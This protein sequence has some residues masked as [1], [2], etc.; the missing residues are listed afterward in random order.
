MERRKKY[1]AYG[2]NLNLGQMARRCPT[3][4]VIGKGEIKDHELLFRGGSL[5]AVATVEPKAGSNVPV[6]IWEIEPEDER[7]LDIY[8][9]YPRLYGKVDLEVQTEDGS[10]SIMAYTMNEGH[11]IGKPSMRYLETITTGY[12][13]AGFD[14]NRL[15]QSVS[16]CSEDKRGFYA[17]LL[18]AI[19]L[20]ILLYHEI[21]HIVNGHIDYIKDRE[22]ES[23]IINDLP[24]AFS[25]VGKK[26]RPFI[27]PEEWQAL[28]WNADDFSA[29]RIVEKYLSS[30]TIEKLRLQGPQQAVAIIVSSYTAL[31]TLME[32][33]VRCENAEEY[34]SFEHLPKRIRLEKSLA[35][36]YDYFNSFKSYRIGKESKEYLEYYK[37]IF[38]RWTGLFLKN[39][40]LDYDFI[41]IDENN[42]LEE[43]DDE[44]REYYKRVENYYLMNLPLILDK[45]AK[46]VICDPASMVKGALLNMIQKLHEDIDINDMEIGIIKDGQIIDIQ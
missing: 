35:S 43:L 17:E 19:M 44:H 23:N 10:E 6:L 33:G 30:D 37:K 5:S 3:A 27:S 41:Q 45:Y 1:I 16:Y 12:L 15:L 21:G 4:R 29:S 2:S 7:N 14:V 24:Y 22:K 11:E 39:Y 18:T 31:Y 8:E 20:D 13:E 32:M 36:V 9:G 34:K 40:F 42:N 46:I 26:A 38:E 25:Y 28:E